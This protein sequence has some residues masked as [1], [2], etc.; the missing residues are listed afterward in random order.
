MPTVPPSSRLIVLGRAKSARKTTGGMR[1]LW[2]CQCTCGRIQVFSGKNLR[3]GRKKHCGWI[4][5]KGDD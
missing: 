5:H 3:N 2:H 1:S 4:G